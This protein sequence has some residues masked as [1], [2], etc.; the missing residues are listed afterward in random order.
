MVA[1]AKALK[2]K[3]PEFLGEDPIAHPTYANAYIAPLDHIFSLGNLKNSDG[4]PIITDLFKL[5]H[6]SHYYRFPKNA[7]PIKGGDK[8]KTSPTIKD[9]E[10]KKNGMLLITIEAL[11]VIVASKD[12]LKVGK[13]VC[14]S[15]IGMIITPG[16]FEIK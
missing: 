12:E 10:I 2:V 6:G 9:A 8:I 16:G 1:Y 5:L 7:P 13:E 3:Q 15:E 11:S 4:S 14:I